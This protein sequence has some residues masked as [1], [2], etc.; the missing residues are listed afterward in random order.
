MTFDS[1]PPRNPPLD[2][3]FQVTGASGLCV[4]LLEMTV[5]DPLEGNIRSH[6]HQVCLHLRVRASKLD[7]ISTESL[8]VK[9]PTLSNPA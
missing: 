2:K 8:G 9:S 6:S 7:T 3:Q 1:V 5:N 4:G